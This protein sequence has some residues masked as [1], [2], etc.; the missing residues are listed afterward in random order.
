MIFNQRKTWFWFDYVTVKKFS[1]TY[2]L[3]RIQLEDET[4]FW[5]SHQTRIFAKR[6]K[7]L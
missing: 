7:S 2:F 5:E 6:I 4:G 1:H 3:H